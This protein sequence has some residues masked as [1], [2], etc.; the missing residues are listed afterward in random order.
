VAKPGVN[1]LF[2]MGDLSGVDRHQFAVKK[3]ARLE[4]F[5]KW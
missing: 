3:L 2:V 4:F 1:G 5:I